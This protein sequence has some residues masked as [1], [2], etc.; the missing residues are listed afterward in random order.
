MPYP[1]ATLC[2][3]C[4]APF[5]RRAIDA[6]ERAC[7]QQAVKVR[8]LGGQRAGRT[9]AAS[10]A[11]QFGKTEPLPPGTYSMTI[12]RIRKVR[13]KPYYRIHYQLADGSTAT[14]IMKP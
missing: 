2:R 6:H 14:G 4:R 7:G 5:S 9:F 12:T 10:D 11:Q 13:N 8:K 1:P 3:H